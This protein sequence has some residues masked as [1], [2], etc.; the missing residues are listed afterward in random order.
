M[1]AHQREHI[2]LVQQAPALSSTQS[3][4]ICLCVSHSRDAAPRRRARCLAIGRHPGG[5][6]R[7]PAAHRRYVRDFGSPDTERLARHEPAC[8]ARPLLHRKYVTGQRSHAAPVSHAEPVTPDGRRADTSIV[9]TL[10]FMQRSGALVHFLNTIPTFL[11]Y[12]RGAL[13]G[14]NERR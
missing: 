7:D 13:V 3:A 1:R 10:N 5:G 2:W 11:G 4:W 9:I 12:P 14:R 6:S 8:G